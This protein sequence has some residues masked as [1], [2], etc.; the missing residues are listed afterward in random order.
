MATV[1]LHLV[2][3]RSLELGL[4][5]LLYLALVDCYSPTYQL[6]LDDLCQLAALQVT[7]LALMPI[8]KPSLII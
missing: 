5:S 8:S 3:H 7:K 6:L 4:Q 2:R 1:G